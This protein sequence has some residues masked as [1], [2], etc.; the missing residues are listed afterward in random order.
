MIFTTDRYII[1]LKKEMS[2][3]SPRL[4]AVALIII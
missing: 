2:E 3:M 4:V 1:I